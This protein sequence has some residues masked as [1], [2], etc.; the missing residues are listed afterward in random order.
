[1]VYAVTATA[2]NW[3]ARYLPGFHEIP[4]RWFR[5]NKIGLM[6]QVQYSMWVTRKDA[7]YFANMTR[8]WSVKACIMS[9]LSGMK[10]HGEFWRDGAGVH[11][12]N[13]RGTAEIGFV[14]GE[15]WRWRILTIISGRRD[16]FR[17][18]HY[19]ARLGISRL[20]VIRNPLKAQ[21]LAEE[22]NNKGE[23]YAQ[24]IS[25][26][27]K[28]EYRDGTSLAQ[29]GVRFVPIPVETDEEFIR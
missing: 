3:N 19:K 16:H 15:Q 4:A 6:A 25:R 2:L 29:I 13:G 12:K 20:S 9:W 18:L 7:W 27:V 28:N 23:L 17:L 10:I 24:S 11:R 26:W 5:G 8:A 21:R 1:M 14:F 22:I